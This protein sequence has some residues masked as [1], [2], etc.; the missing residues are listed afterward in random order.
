MSQNSILM[1]PLKPVFKILVFDTVLEIMD[2]NNLPN[3]CLNRNK[4]ITATEFLAW[5]TVPQIVHN[6]DSKISEISEL[7]VLHG[8][9]TWPESTST[10]LSGRH[11]GHYKAVKATTPGSAFMFHKIH[12]H[13]SV[14]RH[15]CQASDV[16]IEKDWGTIHLF[17]ADFNF[18]S[19]FIGDIG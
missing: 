10:L 18:L 5:V 3:I 15:S 2:E 9:K 4:C 14:S 7:E 1:L 19:N 8:F 12:E 16:L 17:E 11:L 13:S 6:S